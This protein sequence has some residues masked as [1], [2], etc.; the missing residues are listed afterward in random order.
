MFE[1]IHQKIMIKPVFSNEKIKRIRYN[2][3]IFYFWGNCD[4]NKKPSEKIQDGFT[5][6]QIL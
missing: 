1:F 3:S 6:E 2:S 4:E 5:F